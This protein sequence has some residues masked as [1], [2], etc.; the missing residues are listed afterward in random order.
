MNKYFIATGIL[1]F[2]LVTVFVLSS[3]DSAKIK[4]VR[5]INENIIIQ[6]TATPIETKDVKVASVKSNI[7]TT[8]VTNTKTYNVDSRVDNMTFR[9]QSSDSNYGI[10]QTRYNEDIS[11]YNRQL[12]N[13]EQAEYNLRH[14]NRNDSSDRE[15]KYKFDEYQ[16]TQ[17]NDSIA[18]NQDRYMEKDI[19]WNTWKSNFVNQ[20]LDDS[21]SIRALDDYGMGT[22]FYYSFNVTSE[23]KIQDIKVFSVYLE[24]RDKDKITKLIGSYAYK[25]ITKFPKHTKR[26]IA[27]VNAVVLLGS[28]EKRSNPSDFHE[29]ERVRIKY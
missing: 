18:D 19:D 6:N 8:T 4:R 11:R 23:G 10:N 2:V 12:K 16:R 17:Q 5:F 14:Q 22:W 25:P 7:E 29:N 24:P 1:I 27:N 26:K 9:T 20:V 28:Q 21:E 13:L 15:F 3:E